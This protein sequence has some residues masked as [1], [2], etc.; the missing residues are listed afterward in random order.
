MVPW[1]N[2]RAHRHISKPCENRMSYTFLLGFLEQQRFHVAKALVSM[3]LYMA[4]AA[5]PC[6]NQQWRFTLSFPA[7]LLG[8]RG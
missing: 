7:E 4:S 6:S 3:T 8:A 1:R 5:I 2:G